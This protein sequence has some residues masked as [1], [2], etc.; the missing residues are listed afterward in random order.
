MY[1]LDLFVETTQLRGNAYK[2][3]VS[4]VLTSS[5]DFYFHLSA[6]FSIMLFS[7][8]FY[9]ITPYGFTLCEKLSVYQGIFFFKRINMCYT[10]LLLL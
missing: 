7:L 10:K 4:G 5:L 3:P 6:I 1:S 9:N 2:Q 8:P